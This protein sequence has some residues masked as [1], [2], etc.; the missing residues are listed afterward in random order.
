ME[1][2]KPKRTV[3]FSKFEEY[4]TYEWVA[5]VDG[6]QTRMELFLNYDEIYKEEK[7]EKKLI[8]WIK[9]LYFFFSNLNQ[10]YLLLK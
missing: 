8:N 3:T 9:Y 2:P 6:F 7:S 5:P 10:S 4:V 1:N